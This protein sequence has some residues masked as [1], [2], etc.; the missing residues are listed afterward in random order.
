MDSLSE[1]NAPAERPGQPVQLDMLPTPKVISVSTGCAT[2]KAED[3]DWFTDDSVVVAD[4]PSVAIYHNRMGNIVIRAEARQDSPD[5]DP[6]IILSTRQSA[7][8]VIEAL[9][10]ALREMRDG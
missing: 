10:R 6:C 5:E 7:S 2:P 8:A 1:L 9:K 3:F 4:Q